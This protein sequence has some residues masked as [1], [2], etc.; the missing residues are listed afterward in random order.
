M[1]LDR[2]ARLKGKVAETEPQAGRQRIPAD[3]ALLSQLSIPAIRR[4]IL[5]LETLEVI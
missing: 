5:R 2:F 3:L 1:I 4:I